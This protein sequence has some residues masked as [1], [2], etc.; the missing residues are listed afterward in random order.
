MATKI[1]T[2]SISAVVLAFFVGLEVIGIS[3]AARIDEFFAISGLGV[4]PPSVRVGSTVALEFEKMSKFFYK[5]SIPVLL[6]TCKRTV[7]E[8]SKLHRMLWSLK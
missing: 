5:N 3:L 2:S 7:G 6:A 4:E 8:G 1:L